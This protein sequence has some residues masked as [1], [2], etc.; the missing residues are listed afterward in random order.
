MSAHAIV[1]AVSRG[2]LFLLVLLFAGAAA[3]QGEGEDAPAEDP[4][5][6]T[7]EVLFDQGLEDMQAANYERGCPA[8][9][10]SYRLEPLPGALFTLAEC[11]R[12]W[13]KLATAHG[14]YLEYLSQ[15]KRMAADKR[16]GQ[17]ERPKVAEEHV[18]QLATEVPKLMIVLG[19][20]IPDTAI[21]K[22]DG[23]RVPP[24]Q[25]GSAIPLDPGRHEL[26]LD[27]PGRELVTKVVNLESGRSERVTLALPE[28]KPDPEPPPPPEEGMSTMRLSAYIVGGVGIAGLI[29]GV[30]AGAI[31]INRANEIDDN[32]VELVCNEKGISK[33]ETVREAGD[34]ATTALVIGGAGLAAGIVL[35]LLSEEPD[36]EASS[37]TGLIVSPRGVGIRW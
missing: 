26:T 37:D 2:L 19:D 3:A 28:E 6:S 13:G 5:K 20:G 27:V 16:A 8:L 29:T 10:E 14:H 24:T 31:A 21:V 30:I 1:G 12:M 35:W 25:L 23:I 32:C 17:G 11:E 33:V 36:E 4:P 18:S 15:V 34:I 22:R 9:A 7:A